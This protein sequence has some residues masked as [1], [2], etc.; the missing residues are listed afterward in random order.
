M[1]RFIGVLS[2]KGGVAKT[3]TSI[4]LAVALNYFGKDVTVIDANLTTP[5]IGVYLGVPVVPINFHHVLQGVNDLADAVYSHPC[6]IK[7]IP[8][9]IALEDLK[10]TKPDKMPKLVSMLYGTTDYVIVDGA[11]GLGKEALGTIKSVDEVLIVTN[12]ELPALT[13]ALKTIRLCE[14][15]GKEVTGVVL[16]KTLP[17]NIGISSRN[18]E[19]ILEKPVISVVPYDP[20]VREALRLR[21]AVVC[22]HP[23]SISSNSYKLLAANILGEDFVVEKPKKGLLKRLRDRLWG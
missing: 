4:N 9:S 11:A 22:T 21:D 17:D 10:K 1:T 7:I 15:M 3:T 2:G 5:N 23:N 16:T 6:G 20:C 18:V 19:T 13:D 8:A 12:P 14:E